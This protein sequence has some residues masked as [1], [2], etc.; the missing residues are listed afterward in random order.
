MPELI[1]ASSSPYRRLL[2]EKLQL[3]F[4][5][6]SPEV[7][8]TPLPNETAKQLVTRLAESKARALQLRFPEALILGS[9]QVCCLGDRQL[10]KPGGRDQ[11]IEQLSY[12]QGQKVSF[13]TGLCLLNAA[14]NQAHTLVDEFR[15]HF[16][17]LTPEQIAAYVDREQ[18]WDCAGS[19]KSEG[20]GIALFNKLEGDDPNS[21][22]GLPLIRLSELLRQQGIEVLSAES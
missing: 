22:I 14:T 17:S 5:C 1:L 4:R 10:G 7:N 15:V 13:L 18:P 8:E 6:A 20:L 19:F 11:A 9:D 21:L 12:L 2:L 3:K 16:R